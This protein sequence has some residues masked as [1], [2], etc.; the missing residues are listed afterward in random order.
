MNFTV[1]MGNLVT[2]NQF[3]ETELNNT[4]LSDLNDT[5]DSLDVTK[6]VTVSLKYFYFP[7]YLIVIINSD[8]PETARKRKRHNSKHQ[9]SHTNQE[10]HSELFF[11]T[12]GSSFTKPIPQQNAINMEKQ[13]FTSCAQF[14]IR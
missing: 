4:G 12:I 8:F 1:K 6:D 2:K 10:Q 3:K 5:V 9:K 13:D 14:R 7:S 11:N